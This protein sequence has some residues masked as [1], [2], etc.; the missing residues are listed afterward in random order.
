MP[1]AEC[2]ARLFTA[3]SIRKNAPESS[4]VYGLSN[5]REWIFIGEASNIQARL[6]EHLQERDTMLANRRPTGFTFEECPP[7]NRLSRQ[8]ALVRQF[9]PFCN[10]RLGY[11]KNSAPRKVY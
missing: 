10:R 6:M 5:G 1:F 8:D 11:I 3:V 4:G 7:D 9:E 2:A